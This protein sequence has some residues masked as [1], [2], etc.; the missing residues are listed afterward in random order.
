MSHSGPVI[1]GKVRGEAEKGMIAV[2]EA[3]KPRIEK[4]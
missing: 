1:R 2:L 3:T 4:K